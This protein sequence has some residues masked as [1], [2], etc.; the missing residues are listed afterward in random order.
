MFEIG[1]EHHLRHQELRVA[2]FEPGLLQVPNNDRKITEKIMVD[3]GF[4]EEPI[5]MSREDRPGL[6]VCPGL[7]SERAGLGKVDCLGFRVASA[8][9]DRHRLRVIDG[10][11]DGNQV[12]VPDLLPDGIECR[13]IT[14]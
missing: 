2:L 13:G 10:Q 9:R 7:R 12:L 4:R 11:D 14:H 3:P 6:Y 1:H 8:D 5:G